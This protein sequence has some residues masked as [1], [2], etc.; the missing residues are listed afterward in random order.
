MHNESEDVFWKC[1]RFTLGT[2]E[3]TAVI[4]SQRDCRLSLCRGTQWWTLW[5]SPLAEVDMLSRAGMSVVR[6]W[7]R[8]GWSKWLQPSLS[9]RGWNWKG[10]VWGVGPPCA[11]LHWLDSLFSKSIL[12]ESGQIN[13][14]TML[15]GLNMDCF[16]KFIHNMYPASAE[17]EPETWRSCMECHY[18]LRTFWPPASQETFFN[19]Q[20]KLHSPAC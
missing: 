18:T 12:L 10:L 17:F 19:T 9:S 6:G 16:I 15:H 11:A 4:K 2:G 13:Y 20:S 1:V 8:V 7:V 14:V 5:P 3:G